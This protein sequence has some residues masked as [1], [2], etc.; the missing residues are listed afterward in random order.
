MRPQMLA[1]FYWAFN[2]FTLSMWIWLPFS[3]KIQFSFTWIPHSFW[4]PSESGF[5]STRAK[6]Y[7]CLHTK[8][9]PVEGLVPT[10]GS[11][12]IAIAR[13]SFLFCPPLRES[14]WTSWRSVRSNCTRT[15]CTL[16]TRENKNMQNWSY[17][18]LYTVQEKTTSEFNTYMFLNG[19]AARKILQIWILTLRTIG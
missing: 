2:I 12:K 1:I 15:F 13:E 19:F 11:P 10:W 9:V 18:D 8:T 6:E 16:G 14:A 5:Q 7:R 17:S 3:L 4:Q